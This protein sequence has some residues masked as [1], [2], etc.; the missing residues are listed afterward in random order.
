MASTG[1]STPVHSTS[2]AA[3]WCTSIPRPSIAVA[4]RAIASASHGHAGRVD[5]VGRHLTRSEQV[6][7]DEPDPRA[8]AVGGHAGHPHRRG[9]DDQIGRHH[10]LGH[11]SVRQRH[12]RA[13]RTRQAGCLVGPFGRP[14]HDRHLG[15]PARRQG[16]HDGPRGAT[17]TH[18][19]AAPALR[20]EPRT[21][22]QG[23][24]EPLAV[25]VGPEQ[26]TVPVDDAVD[27]AQPARHVAALVDQRGH[28]G[29]VRHGDRQPGD[30]G[31]AHRLER[32]GGLARG[33]LEREGAPRVGQPERVE[34]GV[35][36]DGRKGVRHRTADD[37]DD[38]GAGTGF[39]AGACH[40]HGSPRD[41]A[42][43]SLACCS[44]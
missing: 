18:H 3:A 2:C 20:D 22:G 23:R 27:G 13:R 31:P 1:G 9:V 7:G 12:D 32:P 15:R 4:P 21:A 42:S 6:R 29:L 38:G 25:G 14:V 34:G 10:G 11:G 16:Q 24:H 35:V 30:A 40:R 44:A 17:G 5:Q 28:V 33:D 19:D 26:G 36:Q 41:F 37:A 43:C 39:P 8:A